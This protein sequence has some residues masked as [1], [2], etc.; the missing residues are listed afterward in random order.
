MTLLVLGLLL[1]QSDALAPWRE[2]VK[3]TRVSSEDLHSIHSYFVASPESPDGQRILF[4]ASGDSTGHVGQIRILERSTGKARVLVERVEA[5][6]AHRA[7]C[8]QWISGGRRV[9]FHALRSNRWAVVCVDVETARERV[10]AEDRMVGWG[11]PGQ[12]VVP[13]YGPHWNPGEHRNLELLDVDTGALETVLKAEDVKKAYPEWL[14]RRFG[15]RPVSI[16]FPILSPDLERVMFKIA[17]P[18]GGDFRSANASSREGLFFGDLK[19]RRLLSMRESWGHPSWHA[20]CRTVINMGTVLID[21]ESGKH[22]PV[23]GLPKFPGS[24][25][26]FS[27]DGKLFTTDT[28]AEPFGGPKGSWAIV[29]GSPATGDFVILHRFDNTRGAR[30]WRRSHP[31]PAFS[32][33]GRRIYFNVSSD[34]WTRL[35]VAERTR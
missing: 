29:V 23:A 6:D 32:A 8:Q 30:S 4:Y 2:G 22:T 10:L 26:S 12:N 24:H 3:V 14:A 15:E 16:F 1:A 17:T 21:C 11:Q 34:D 9:V 7:A 28:D 31:H 35:H 5:E 27:P 25:P 19:G 20:D 33:D 13:L 18:A